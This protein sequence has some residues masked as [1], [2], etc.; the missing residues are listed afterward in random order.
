MRFA[1]QL[2]ARGA[3]KSSHREAAGRGDP[4]AVLEGGTAVVVDAP[5]WIAA[6]A[7]PPRNDGGAGVPSSRAKRGDPVGRP[8]INMHQNGLQHPSGKRNQLLKP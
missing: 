7:S 1:R 4:V 3:K 8:P 6:S 2:S 5:Y